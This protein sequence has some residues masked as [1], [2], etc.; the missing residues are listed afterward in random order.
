MIGRGSDLA[1]L[2]ESVL[3]P[4]R[5]IAPQFTTYQIARTDGTIVTA[6]I[7]VELGDGSLL[8]A[9]PDGRTF[10]VKSA[11]IEEVQAVSTSIMPEG[12]AHSLTEQEF[13]DLLAFLRAPLPEADSSRVVEKR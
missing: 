7:K 8:C 2:A 5:E 6:L 4:N 12:L 10:T 9:D 11:E 3:R 13:R 1:K